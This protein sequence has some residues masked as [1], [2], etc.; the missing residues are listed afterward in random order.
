MV[1]YA[2]PMIVIMVR[3]EKHP[4]LNRLTVTVVSNYDYKGILQPTAAT[5]ATPPANCQ[6]G[7]GGLHIR[8][9]LSR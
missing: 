9:K 4:C 7:S 6:C 1:G 5:L 2:N 8:V 3:K